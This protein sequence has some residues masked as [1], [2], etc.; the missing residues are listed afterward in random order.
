ME[1][2]QEHK[3]RIDGIMSEVDC[4]KDFAC[5]KSGFTKLGRIGDIK[6]RAFLECLEEDAHHCQFSLS[7]GQGAFCLCPVRI[8]IATELGK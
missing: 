1:I 2:A 8:Y 7:F 5:Y 3:N 6:S 4:R